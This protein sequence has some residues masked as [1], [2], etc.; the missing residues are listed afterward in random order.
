[1]LTNG[2]PYEKGEQFL[3]TEIQILSD[4]FD[5]ISIYSTSTKGTKRDLPANAT[6]KTFEWGSTFSVKKMILRHPLILFKVLI[7][8]F[9]SSKRRKLYKGKFKFHF[10]NL[11]GI[12]NDAEN[13]KNELEK[14]STENTIIYS[15]WFGPWGDVMTM[16]NAMNNNQF[17]FLSRVHGYDYDVDQRKEGFIPFRNFQMN[18]IQ[19]ISAVS[20]YAVDR[21]KDEYPG[22]SDVSLSRLGVLEHG[23]NPFNQANEFTIVSCSSLIPL[24]RVHLIIE[25]LQRLNLKIN[26][27][28]FGDGPLDAEIKSKAK[29]LPSNIDVEFKGFVANS[30]VLDYY[31]NNQVDLFINVSELEG[32]PVS[33]MEAISFSIPV[34]GCK[35]CGVPE[36]VNSETGI[37][38]DV[39]FDMD[40]AA[41]LI[42]DFLNLPHQEKVVFRKGVKSFWKNKFDAHTN[43]TTFIN[44]ILLK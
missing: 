41:N 19:R 21:L 31:K 16:V 8:E 10:N 9:L 32:I 26:W 37:L 6:F 34:V 44:E 38:L 22:Y 25:L 23:E 14:Y 15:Y 40:E 12:M 29:N 11:L 20:Q 18:Y 27:V 3:E 43:Y 36:I 17:P 39:A 2:F 7:K 30:E 28:H 4:S 5:E 33:I 13:F 42:R 1:M 24:K 35:V